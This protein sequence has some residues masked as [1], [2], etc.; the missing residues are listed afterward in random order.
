MIYVD[1]VRHNFRR[2]VM[3]H[4]WTDGDISELHDFAARLGLRREWFQCPPAASWEH[5]DVTLSVKAKAL[6]AGAILT[7]KY[8]PLWTIHSRTVRNYRTADHDNLAR[9]IHWLALIADLRK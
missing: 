1:D 4:L 6:A 9:A 5:Y 3:C 8:G 2:M 7:D